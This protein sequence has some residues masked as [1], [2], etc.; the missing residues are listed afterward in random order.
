MYGLEK[1]PPEI[2]KFPL[3]KAIVAFS[4]WGAFMEKPPTP[5]IIGYIPIEANT[6]QAPIAPKSSFPG[7]PEGLF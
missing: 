5:G 4:N 3:G 7:N 6:Y 1:S 2:I